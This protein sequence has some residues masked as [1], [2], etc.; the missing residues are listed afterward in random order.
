MED[1]NPPRRP[2]THNLPA[3]L[4]PVSPDSQEPFN[5]N[6][7]QLF[8]T[9][10]YCEVDPERALELLAQKVPIKKYVIAREEHKSGHP[11]L[12]CYLKLERKIHTRDPTFFDLSDEGTMRAFARNRKKA[13]QGCR[14]AIAVWKYCRKDGDFITNMDRPPKSNPYKEAIDLADAGDADAAIGL[15]KR[16]SPRDFCTNYDR[17]QN[18]FNKIAPKADYNEPPKHELS[19]FTGW[20]PSWWDRSNRTLI[21]IGRSEAGKTELAKALLPRNFYTKDVE[22]LNM[23]NPRAYD[24]II[25]DDVSLLTRSNGQERSPSEQVNIVEP[26]NATSVRVLYKPQRISSGTPKIVTWHLRNILWCGNFLD[27]GVWRR[28]TMVRVIDPTK[29]ELVDIPTLAKQHLPWAHLDQRT[30]D[31]VLD[32]FEANSAKMEMEESPMPGP[33]PMPMPMPMSPYMQQGSQG[34]RRRSYQIRGRG[35]EPFHFL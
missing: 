10:D 22:A 6:S 8:L 3:A 30:P 12:H 24:G 18:T 13:Y 23:F 15:I 27:K 9:Y 17:L 20:D 26:F 32:S 1:P 35:G 4:L 5:L 19:T 16:A 33:M 28:C 29:M 31:D 14:S 21:L 7:S 2:V 11:H 25:L 34:G